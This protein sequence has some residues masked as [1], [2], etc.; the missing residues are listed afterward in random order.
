MKQ[1][2]DNQLINYVAPYIYSNTL[3]PDRSNFQSWMCKLNPIL[4]KKRD[5]MSFLDVDDDN[6]ICINQELKE[7]NF[8]PN[9]ANVSPTMNSQD[10]TSNANQ[11][12]WNIFRSTF[13]FPKM[14]QNWWS[15][16][17]ITI[18]HLFQTVTEKDMSGC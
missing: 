2:I 8:V 11:W 7:K 18:L 17:P 10:T 3:I 12:A 1:F 9:S 6:F 16:W 13:Q 5:P 15:V 14:V 4:G